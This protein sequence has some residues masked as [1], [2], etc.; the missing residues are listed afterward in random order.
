MVKIGADYYL[1]YPEK[2]ARV[3]VAELGTGGR[4]LKRVPA[5]PVVVSEDGGEHVVSADNLYESELAACI[6]SAELAREIE[7]DS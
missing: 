7:E 6:A 1:P 4:N 3:R 2:V 5:N